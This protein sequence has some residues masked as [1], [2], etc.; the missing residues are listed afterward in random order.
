MSRERIL[1]AAEAVKSQRTPQQRVAAAAAAVRAQRNPSIIQRASRAF[2]AG[3]DRLFQPF[4]WAQDI[5]A[6]EQAVRD[7]MRASVAN[8]HPLIRG[9]ANLALGTDE[10]LSGAGYSML[11]PGDVVLT[12]GTGGTSAVA[13]KALI[14]AGRAVSAALGARGVQKAAEGDTAG[15]RIAGGVQAVLGGL[16]ARAVPSAAPPA[17]A[18]RPQP[19]QLTGQVDP[20]YGRT[21][22]TPPDTGA[23]TSMAAKP[24]VLEV[25]PTTGEVKVV[26]YAST[27]DD[28]DPVVRVADPPRQKALP[29]GR[30]T[31][32][33]SWPAMLAWRLCGKATSMQR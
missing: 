11:N 4:Q 30:P 32:V 20:A 18:P 21:V 6:N 13:R 12:A 33:D 10:A 7:R 25:N 27:L 22:H 3:V 31:K 9:A 28:V 8:S 16:G 26:Q 17:P 19:R 14:P 23:R 24:A 15:E 29:A 5:Q 2:G 1:A